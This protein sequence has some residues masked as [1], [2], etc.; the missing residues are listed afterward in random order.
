MAGWCERSSRAGSSRAYNRRGS[1]RSSRSNRL[2]PTSVLPRAAGRMKEGVE[3]SA[4]FERTPDLIRGIERFE[5]VE[6]HSL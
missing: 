1:N 6:N 3:R 2:T 4:A 5:Q